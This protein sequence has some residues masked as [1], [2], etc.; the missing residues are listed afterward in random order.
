MSVTRVLKAKRASKA[1]RVTKV[2]QENLHIN[3]HKRADI[4]ER[5]RSLQK[6]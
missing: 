5:K 6:I 3:M 4:W 1:K 2:M